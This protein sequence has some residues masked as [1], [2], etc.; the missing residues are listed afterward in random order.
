MIICPKCGSCNVNAQ[1]VGIT[2]PKGKGCFYWIFIGWWLEPLLWF[3]L[4]VPMLLAKL[5]GSKGKVKTKVKGYAICQQCGYC[6][7]IK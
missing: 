6:W 5:F 2:T 7:Q 3:F 1:A 4:T